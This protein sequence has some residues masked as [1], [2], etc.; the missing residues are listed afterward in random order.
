LV[1]DGVCGKIGVGPW[2]RVVV[3]VTECKILYFRQTSSDS[4]VLYTV[5]CKYLTVLS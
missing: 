2:G 4:F 1:V 5:H 3:G